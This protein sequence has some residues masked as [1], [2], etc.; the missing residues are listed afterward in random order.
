MFV[1]VPE[2][3]W[4]TSIGN[5][6]S[7]FPKAIS[8]AARPIARALPFGS[9]PSSPL[10]AAAAPFTRASQWTSSMGTV[11]PEIGKFSTALVVSPPHSFFSFGIFSPDRLA[12]PAARRALGAPPARNQNPIRPG[13]AP[14]PAPWPPRSAAESRQLSCQADRVVVGHQEA[15]AREHAQL[16]AREQ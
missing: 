11:S 1:E 14:R 7:S 15:G 12:P 13:P 10:T 9:S 8:S 2:P 6:P 3:V 4:K 5:W 16:A